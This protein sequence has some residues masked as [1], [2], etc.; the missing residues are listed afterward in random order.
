M[1]QQLILCFILIGSSY[2][3]TQAQVDVNSPQQADLIWSYLQLRP[4]DVYITE[5][6]ITLV[7]DISTKYYG[8]PSYAPLIFDANPS[9]EYDENFKS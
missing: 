7:T 6:D 5:N 4:D 1:W 8:G 9:L 3:I 2:Q